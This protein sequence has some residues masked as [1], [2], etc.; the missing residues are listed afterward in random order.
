MEQPTEIIFRN[1]EPSSFVRARVE[2][3]IDKLERYFDRIQSCQ[4]MIEAPH[5]H[6]RKGRE[7][8]VAV[9]MAL[10]KGRNVDVTHAG[11]KDKAHE[12]VYVAIRDAFKAATRQLQDTS[13]VMAGKVKTHDTPEHGHVRTLF[14]DRGYGFIQSSDGREIYFHRN[15]VAEGSF[16]ALHQGDDVRFVSTEGESAEG[17]QA[18]TVIPIG[19]HHLTD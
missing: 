12:D 13:N 2:E 16:D 1:M 3:E 11:R 7:Y 10:P 14:P 4:V 6:H 17:P 9:H 18:S 8:H 15:S 5:K 19:K